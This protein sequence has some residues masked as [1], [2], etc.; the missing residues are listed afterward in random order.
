MKLYP[1][2]LIDELKYQ[3][4]ETKI[5]MN[6]TDLMTVKLRYKNPEEDKSL[7]L[8]RVITAN[9]LSSSQSEDFIWSASVAAFGMKLRGSDYAKLDY[10]EI[11]QM[12]KSAKGADI[13][14]YRAELIQ[15]IEKAELI[16]ESGD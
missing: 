8:D 6:T 15:L 12:A 14:G 7:Y 9:E 3:Q 16:D 4:S 5:A 2:E 10:A 1:K 13:N 11:I